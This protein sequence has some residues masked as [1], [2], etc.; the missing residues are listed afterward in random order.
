MRVFLNIG[1]TM[2]DTQTEQTA[3]LLFDEFPSLTVADIKLFF[4]KI[5][6]GT[7]W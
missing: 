4:N 7:L 6:K 3:M 2:S 5:K 1:K